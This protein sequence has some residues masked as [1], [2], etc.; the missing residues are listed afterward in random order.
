MR[1]AITCL[2]MAIIHYSFFIKK[3][4]IPSSS[5]DNVTKSASARTSGAAFAMAT[6]LPAKR[7]MERSL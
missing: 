7:I 6:P 2:R 4:A 5:F 3:A 1:S